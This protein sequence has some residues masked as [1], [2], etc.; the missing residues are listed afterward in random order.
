MTET[1][2][3]MHTLDQ[4]QIALADLAVRGLRS[5]G[6]RERA[7]LAGL[8]T[9]LERVGADHLASRVAA[10]LAGLDGADREAA[11]A[12]LRAQASVRLF[13]RVLTLEIAAEALGVL[14]GPAS[15]ETGGTE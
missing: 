9:E 10:V 6:A 11:P 8:R 15:E 14:A 2:E 1:D 5:A 12:L 4:V 7:T 13:E 3:I